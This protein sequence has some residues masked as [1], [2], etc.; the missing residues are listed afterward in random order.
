MLLE[1]RLL[2][3]SSVID[4][5]SPLGTVCICFDLTVLNVLVIIVYTII[6]SGRLA[7]VQTYDYK[8]QK[9]TSVDLYSRKSIV[10]SVYFPTNGLRE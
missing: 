3:L 2:L 8:A 6:L 9:K 1:K 7:E 4:L 10:I 5:V